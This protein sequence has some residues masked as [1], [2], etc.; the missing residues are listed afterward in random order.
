MPVRYHYRITKYDSALRDEHGH[1]T[2]DDWTSISD[3]GDTFAGVELTLA[4][5]LDVEAR[6]L[7]ALASFLEEADV[8]SVTAEG[9][10][11]PDGLRVCEGDRL[12]QLDALDTV[13]QM[14]REEGW[15]R[16][17]HEDRFYLHVGYDYYVYV[18]TDRPCP[19]SVA[20][21]AESGLVVDEDVVSPYL[22]AEVD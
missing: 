9:V 21:A 4:T 22:H 19:R 10:E 16:L 6:H 12:S 5:Y 2:G 18:G 20:L 15:C 13:R 11:N 8:S 17:L 3:I 14:L 7:V 1:F